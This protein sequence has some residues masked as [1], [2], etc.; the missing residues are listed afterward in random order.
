M[1]VLY[2]A[3]YT[4]ERHNLIERDGKCYEHSRRRRVRITNAGMT[5]LLKLRN[6]EARAAFAKVKR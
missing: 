1:Q 6:P 4:M 3:F 5:K 2:T